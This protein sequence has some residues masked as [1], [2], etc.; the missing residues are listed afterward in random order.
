[1][2]SDNRENK[3]LRAKEKVAN[4]KKF[5][6]SL[7]FYVVFIAFLGWLNYYS[8]GW[9]YMWF[10]WAAFGWGIGIVFQGLKAFGWMPFMSKDWEERK[11][12]EFMDEE[13]QTR[14]RWK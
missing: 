10:L 1:M 2:E 12:R 14:Q 8:N 11:I 6:T 3:Y 4:I 5:Y 9:R 7:M 13:E